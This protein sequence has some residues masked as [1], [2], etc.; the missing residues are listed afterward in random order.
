MATWA[1]FAAAEPLLATAIRTLVCQYGPGL[2]YLATVRPD[3][4]PRIHPVSPVITSDGLFCFVLPSPKR[5][6]LDRDGR[7][8]LHSFPG[9]DSDDEAYLSGRATRVTSVAVI[10]GLARQMRAAPGVDWKL[11]ELTVDVAML[12]HH[13][14]STTSTR[15]VWKARR[16]HIPR[17]RHNGPCTAA[18]DSVQ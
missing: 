14:T 6:D 8:S 11:Y 16:D 13:E 5:H 15:T 2:G 7:Y 17:A 9:T 12:V 1:D 18:V 10:A 4:G 3:G